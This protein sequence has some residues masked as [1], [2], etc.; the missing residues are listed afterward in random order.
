MTW[1]FNQ[2]LPDNI[3]FFGEI[4]GSMIFSEPQRILKAIQTQ[5][6]RWVQAGWLLFALFSLSLGSTG[7]SAYRD[8]LAIPCT[9]SD[10]MT[11][12]FTPVEW[13]LVLNDFWHDQA[14]RADID[15][16]MVI[17]ISLALAGSA[18]L[19]QYLLSAHLLWLRVLLG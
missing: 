6:S 14:E 8:L 18:F 10:C 4:Q 17:L 9:G 3:Q 11:G 16:S 7:I 2:F 5:T 13:K 15:T 12:Q 19:F 1:L